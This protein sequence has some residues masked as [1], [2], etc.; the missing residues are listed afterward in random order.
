[1]Q[2]TMFERGPTAIVVVLVYGPRNLSR[3]PRQV[4]SVASGEP[5]GSN[6]SRVH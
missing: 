4:L 3:K 5:H 2:T 6:R 1:M